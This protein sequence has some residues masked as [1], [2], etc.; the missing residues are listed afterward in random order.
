MKR[1]F[2]NTLQKN[3]NE[4]FGQPKANTEE[5]NTF[6]QKYN[7]QIAH[8]I[9][10]L[11]KN[12]EDMYQSCV[13]LFTKTFSLGRIPHKYF[14]TAKRSLIWMHIC[15]S[16]LR[17]DYPRW[18]SLQVVVTFTSNYWAATTNSTVSIQPHSI[19]ARQ[20]IIRPDSPC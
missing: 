17:M 7:L 4:F 11:S 6:T 16:Y 5:E 3:W 9:L 12:I 8:T 20:V 1:F 18:T 19:S 14:Q 13:L 2:H 15:E 10:V